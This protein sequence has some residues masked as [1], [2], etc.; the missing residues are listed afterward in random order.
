MK[1]SFQRLG[2]LL[3]FFSA[4]GYA[5]VNGLENELS[6]KLM[7][8]DLNIL[9]ENLE[10]IHPGLYV[11]T[12]EQEMEVYF[13]ELRASLD[14]P[15]K[16]IV[17]YRKLVSIHNKIRD[18]HTF[19]IPPEE[20]S[21]AVE[22]HLPHFPFDVYHD[23]EKLF[24]LKNFS[25]TTEIDEGLEIISIN[26]LSS[27]EVFDSLI[28][29]WTK[30]G[31]NKTF[32]AMLIQQDFSEFYANIFGTAKVYD[33]VVKKEEI[34]IPYRIDGL[35]ISEIRTRSMQRYQFDKR[36]WYNDNKNPPLQLTLKDGVAILRVPTF[37]INTI[38]DTK[39]DYEDFFK[40]AFT[41]ITNAN[42][43]NLIIDIRGNGG[44]E[45]DVATELFSYLHDKPFNLLKEIHTITN[46]I[47]NKKFFEG[48]V[49]S[50]NFQM[51][52]GLKRIGE[53][54]FTPKPA[55]ARKKHL[56]LED[57]EPATPYYGG[58]VYVL[59]DG[60]S[61]SASGMF[62]ALIKNYNR[63]IFIGEEAGSNPHTQNGDFE[64]MLKLPNSGVRMRIPLLHYKMNVNFE[65]TG[66]G[67]IPDHY[68]K[69]SI[70]EELNKEDAVMEWTLDFIREKKK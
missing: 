15:M 32:P 58:K 2:Y 33:L 54:K 51:K 67:V 26:G 69:N 42:C 45:G 36:P 46:K 49:S 40:A 10:L 25:D 50:T 61:F 27:T 3:L 5:Q 41:K 66:Q 4:F 55:A 17:F 29:S 70:A 37:S 53:N 6:P 7:L 24:I 19:V 1:N 60:W 30:D 59:I 9:K 38:E 64:Q 13:E 35:P 34:E 57:K 56:S 43:N 65:N 12:T 23:G 18:G 20:W 22:T 68:I 28:E 31:Y 16:P 21:V 63:G 14:Q 48:N 47:T 8:Q 39:I 62:T 11:Y 52:A 44:G